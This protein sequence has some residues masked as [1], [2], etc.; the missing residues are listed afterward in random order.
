MKDELEQYLRNVIHGASEQYVDN[1]LLISEK[2]ENDSY[3]VPKL[4][5]VVNKNIAFNF[6]FD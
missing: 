4:N 1:F 3:V 5:S 2:Y 6:E